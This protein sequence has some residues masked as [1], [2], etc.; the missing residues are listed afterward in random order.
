MVYTAN[1]CKHPRRS[2]PV[3]AQKFPLITQLLKKFLTTVLR[4]SPLPGYY[5]RH[6]MDSAASVALPASCVGGILAGLLTAAVFLLTSML[7]PVRL[8]LLFSLCVSLWANIPRQTL[9]QWA[10]PMHAKSAVTLVLMLLLK[11]EI[12]SEVDLDWVPVILI[13]STAWSRAATLSARTA[14]IVGVFP[15]NKFTR[16]SCLAIGMA[17]LCFFGLWPEP[18]WGLWVAAAVTLIAARLIRPQG[19]TA[20]ISVRW[21]A[22]EMIY[23]LCVLALMSAAAITEFTTEE[24]PES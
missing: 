10:T 17:P 4:H 9:T 12:L 1:D 22:V 11:L 21:I 2:C 3:A 7:F 18:A 24:N 16:L 19:F 5:G 6:G 8:A 20:P 15:A 14:P 13:C 23:C